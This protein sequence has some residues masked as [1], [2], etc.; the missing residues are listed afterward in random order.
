MQKISTV[1][2][3]PSLPWVVCFLSFFWGHGR[4]SIR[5]EGRAPQPSHDH[6]KANRREDTEGR[7][8]PLRNGG[9]EAAP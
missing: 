3:L 8:E 6:R 4:G 1:A 5:G 7:E 9:R 2:G